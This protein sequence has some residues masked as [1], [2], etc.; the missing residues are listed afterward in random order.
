MKRDAPRAAVSSSSVG[1]DGTT[2]AEG[3]AVAAALAEELPATL[4]RLNRL[5]SAEE[6]PGLRTSAEG[7]SGKT[8]KGSVPN[9]L[10]CA[11]A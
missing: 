9:E 6:L 2:P 10:S 1:G 5:N 11:R 8:T 4:P 7:V 3:A